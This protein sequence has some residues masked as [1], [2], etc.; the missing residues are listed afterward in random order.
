MVW[1]CF[2][3]KGRGSLK[4]LEKGVTMNSNRYIDT[5]EELLPRIMEIHGTSVFLQDNAPCHRCDILI[6]DEIHVYSTVLY[7]CTVHSK[8]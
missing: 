6:T 5:L 4:F 3:A 2:S 8:V 1:G 7:L